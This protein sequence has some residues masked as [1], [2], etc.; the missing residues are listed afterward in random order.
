MRRVG[1]SRVVP[2]GWKSFILSTSITMKG[3]SGQYLS[4]KDNTIEYHYSILSINSFRPD[5]SQPK[6]NTIESNKLASP[7]ICTT[8]LI[9][10]AA[11]PEPC[12]I[13]VLRTVARN[14]V[15]SRGRQTQSCTGLFSVS[16]SRSHSLSFRT[17][18]PSFSRRFLASVA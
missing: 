14:S 1:A 2:C 4:H 5:S 7:I 11:E 9:P 8:Q 13:R 3:A 18:V 6:A 12:T 10:V 15:A 16:Y 17:G